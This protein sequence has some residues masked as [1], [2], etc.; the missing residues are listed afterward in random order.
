MYQKRLQKVILVSPVLGPTLECVGPCWGAFLQQ[1][2][3]RAGIGVQKVTTVG[4]LLGGAGSRGEACLT[5]QI[6]QS[7]ARNSTH[8]RLPLWGECM[9]CPL[10]HRPLTIAHCFKTFV[11][12]DIWGNG[13][14]Y[15]W[16]PNLSFG[17]LGASTSESWEPLERS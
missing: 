11:I 4:R 6:L 17:R 3:K 14:H 9:G 5:M 13:Y 10:C 8:A 7:M 12:L 16:Y 15:F 1:E 2:E